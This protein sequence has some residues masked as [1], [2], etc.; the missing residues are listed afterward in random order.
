MKEENDDVNIPQEKF[1]TPNEVLEDIDKIRYEEFVHEN[2]NKVRH[3]ICFY[4]Q[5]IGQKEMSGIEKTIIEEMK[6]TNIEEIKNDMSKFRK[7]TTKINRET[8]WLMIKK[9][10][11]SAQIPKDFHKWSRK[12]WDGL[13]NKHPMLA[14]SIVARI[15][16]TERDTIE[17]FSSGQTQESL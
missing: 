17:Y 4:W 15:I 16:G 6:S 7:Y 10:Q 13:I 12:H 5:I 11:E 14:E 8:V 1:W 2:A 9:A 3:K